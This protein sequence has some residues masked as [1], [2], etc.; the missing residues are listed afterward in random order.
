MRI[1]KLDHVQ[2][3]MPSG[4]EDAARAFYQDTLGI[5]EQIKPP[6]LAARGGCWF[7]RGPLKV[8]LGVEKD[9]V[10]ARKAHPAFVVEDLPN[11]V[12]RLERAG[13]RV[14]EDQ[15]LE[16]YERRYVDDPFGNRIE[17]MEPSRQSK[18]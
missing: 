8:H 7:E 15:P 2:L 12:A 3:A 17:L 1:L 14:V 11:L 9:F 10:P 16:G 18:A 13:Y 6:H 5:P 4:K